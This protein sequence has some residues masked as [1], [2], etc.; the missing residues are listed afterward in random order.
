MSLWRPCYLKKQ[1]FFPQQASALCHQQWWSWR[2]SV[3]AVTF[4]SAFWTSELLVWLSWLDPEAQKAQQVVGKEGDGTHS[5]SSKHLWTQDR[6]RSAVSSFHLTVCVCV[7]VW[8]GF[9]TLI[10][11]GK[12]ISYLSLVIG[13]TY[14]MHKVDLKHCVTCF[15]FQRK[16]GLEQSWRCCCGFKW[17]LYGE[18]WLEIT[19]MF[20]YRA[21]KRKIICFYLLTFTDAKNSLVIEFFFSIS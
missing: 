17:F 7:S 19:A 16:G 18:W 4:R 15:L 20:I 12:W 11:G 14:L 10:R 6:S 5:T 21:N 13:S 3:S 9:I 8:K 2:K 1:I